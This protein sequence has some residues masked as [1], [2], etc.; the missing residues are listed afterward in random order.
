M[1]HDRHTF[2][3]V[4]GGWCGG[5]LWRDIAPALRERGH[6]VTTPTLTGLGERRHLEN[7]TA[8][9]S[10]HIEDVIAHI[11]MEGFRDVTL[12]SQSYG[13]MVATGTLA[14]I[15][16]SIRSMI[17]LDAFVPADGE[18]LV[19][20]VPP[21]LKDKF[22]IYKNEDRP[23]PPLPLSHLGITDPALV[24]FMTPRLVNQPW[25]TLFEPVRVLPRPAHVRMSYVRCT[26]NI[27]GDYFDSM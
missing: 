8:R 3:L 20:C 18:S 24:D 10:T 2:V 7:R 13:G 1:R 5:W 6:V 21:E 22:I 19:D 26:A 17:Y 25:R 27:G 9:L 15:P 23:I 16:N 14:R 4:H 12:V 11:E